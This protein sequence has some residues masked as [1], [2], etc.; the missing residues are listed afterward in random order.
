MDHGSCNK[1]RV[2]EYSV[3]NLTARKLSSTT[4]TTD[5][6]GKSFFLQTL[7]FKIVKCVCVSFYVSEST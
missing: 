4:E 6:V 5:K 1:T 3:V 2:F 7:K